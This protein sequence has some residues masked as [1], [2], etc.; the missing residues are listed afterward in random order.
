MD[1]A[2]ILSAPLC[3]GLDPQEAQPLL[4]AL[5]PVHLARGETLFNEGE[6]GERLYVIA[7]GQVKLGR[8]SSDGRASP[9]R[10]R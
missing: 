8:R 9:C 2:V 5:T 7:D 3:A 4:D 10:R 6:R 1:D